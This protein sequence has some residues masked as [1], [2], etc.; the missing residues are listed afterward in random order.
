VKDKKWNERW[1]RHKWCE[2]FEEKLARSDNILKRVSILGLKIFRL[3]LFPSNIVV[4]SVD[5]VD[6]FI[7]MKD[8]RISPTIAI[9]AK[10]FLF[11]D[12]YY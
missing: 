2:L 8:H 4:M 6:A 10:I 5:I 1:H 12:Y 7:K 3:E 11:L 9:L